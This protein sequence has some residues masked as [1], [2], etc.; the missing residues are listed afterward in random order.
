MSITTSLSS[1]QSVSEHSRRERLGAELP[2]NEDPLDGSIAPIG[3]S[4][5]GLLDVVDIG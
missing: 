1:S 3:T 5:R 4:Y 2:A